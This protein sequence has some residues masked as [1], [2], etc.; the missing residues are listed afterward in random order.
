MQVETPSGDTFS[1]K[2]K[3]CVFSKDMF[4]QHTL[5]ESVLGE[6]LNAYMKQN[7]VKYFHDCIRKLT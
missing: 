7:L 5:Y 4:N 6:W 2:C 1:P 3:K